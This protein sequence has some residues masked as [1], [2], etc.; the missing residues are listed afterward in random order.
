MSRANDLGSLHPSDAADTKPDDP[1]D[2]RSE[3][4]YSVEAG[5]RKQVTTVGTTVNHPSVT[6]FY[7]TIGTVIIVYKNGYGRV[8]VKGTIQRAI[9]GIF[10]ARE[11]EEVFVSPASY[12]RDGAYWVV[13]S[14]AVGSPIRQPPTGIDEA[15][16]MVPE[17]D[18]YY[19]NLP[20]D[21]G[22]L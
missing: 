9:I 7:T 21:P 13:V 1:I 20:E 14:R 8:R 17:L 18:T 2:L 6:S 15:T 5:I 11:G 10:T 12:E 22:P 3:L 16:L 4:D 19:S